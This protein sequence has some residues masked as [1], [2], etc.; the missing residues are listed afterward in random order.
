MHGGMLFIPPEN[1]DK[2]DQL[3]SNSYFLNYFMSI[4]SKYNNKFKKFGYQKFCA[5]KS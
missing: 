4:I 3:Y 1:N 2:I 5:S